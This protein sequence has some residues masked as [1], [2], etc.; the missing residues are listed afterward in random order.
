M[1][2]LD[3]NELIDISSIINLDYKLFAHIKNDEKGIKYYENLEDH[4]KLSNK[5]FFKICEKRNLENVF[6][7]FEDFYLKDISENAKRLFR[8]LLINVV[9]FHDIGKINPKFQSEKMG[10][11]LENHS[12]FSGVGS[13]HSIISSIIYIDYFWN[14]VNLLEKK[15]D[16]KKLK[17]FLFLNAYLLSKHHGDLDSYECFVNSI[18]TG[19]AKEVIKILT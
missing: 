1:K 14:E 15:E 7:K 18:N 3:K 16:K 19:Q 6:K 17:E 4:I 2:Y 12:E 5:Y 10:N 11:K 13:N 9:N 8:K